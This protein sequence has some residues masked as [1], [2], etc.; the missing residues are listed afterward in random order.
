MN[1]NILFESPSKYHLLFENGIDRI[2]Q[3]YTFDNIILFH[4][5][6]IL[7]YDDRR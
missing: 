7:L 3:S 4:K 6:N 1:A 5:I 2:T